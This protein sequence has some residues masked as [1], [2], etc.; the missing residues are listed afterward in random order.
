MCEFASGPLMPTY[1]K[2]LSIFHSTIYRTVF[3]KVWEPLIYNN[4]T[5]V[6][7]GFLEILGIFLFFFCLIKYSAYFNTIKKDF[8]KS[9][10]YY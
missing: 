1:I 2:L 6:I 8:F 3:E 7:E 10:F 5:S 4:E 9:I